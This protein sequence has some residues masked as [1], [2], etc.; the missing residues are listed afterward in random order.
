MEKCNNTSKVMI[1][2]LGGW[3]MVMGLQLFAVADVG[4]PQ[5]GA[6]TLLGAPTY[7]FVKY[8]QKIGPWVPRAPL[9]SANALSSIPFSFDDN[10][11]VSFIFSNYFTLFKF[12]AVCSIKQTK[13]RKSWPNE[14]I[15][16]IVAMF[17]KSNSM[18]RKL[19]VPATTRTTIFAVPPPKDT[20][21]GAIGSD[22]EVISS[23][24]SRFPIIRSCSPTVYPS[25]THVAIA[26]TYFWKLKLFLPSVTVF[27]ER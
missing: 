21:V 17:E 2:N 15:Y 23:V 20:E 27:A 13:Y 19:A 1:V 25:P 10:F 11:S 24:T 8:S 16:W 18:W 6:T 7:N 4:F 22:V 9:R 5:G 12:N 3:E 26:E 14:L